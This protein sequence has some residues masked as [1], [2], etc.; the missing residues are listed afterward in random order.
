MPGRQCC[1]S[2]CQGEKDMV[3]VPKNAIHELK[4]WPCYYLKEDVEEKVTSYSSDKPDFI[5]LRHLSAYKPGMENGIFVLHDI[6]SCPIVTDI[7]TGALLPQEGYLLRAFGN[8]PPT[9]ENG[10]TQYIVNACKLFQTSLREARAKSFTSL[11]PVATREERGTKRTATGDTKFTDKDVS[12]VNDDE[13]LLEQKIVNLQE[14]LKTSKKTYGAKSAAQGHEH[15][16]IVAQL[17]S[18]ILLLQRNLKDAVDEKNENKAFKWTNE[19]VLKHFSET[20]FQALTGLE[21]NAWD[22]YTCH[23]VV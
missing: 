2:W 15:S 4:K 16:R 18:E 20:D 23:R 5:C 10:Y 17:Q 14:E 3:A 19:S 22:A 13:L 7:I 11:L 12:Q 6:H 21:K 1:V 8:M 9:F